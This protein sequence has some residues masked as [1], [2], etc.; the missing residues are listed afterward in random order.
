[1]TRSA[2]VFYFKFRRQFIFGIVLFAICLSYFAVALL[3]TPKPMEPVSPF[4]F[5]I[6]IGF[7]AYFS[8]PFLLAR[9]VV[10]DDSALTFKPIN[11]RYP[12]DRIKRIKQVYKTNDR[13]SAVQL[14]TE[15]GPNVWLPMAIIGGPEIVKMS[16]TN[17]DGQAFVRS[18]EKRIAINAKAPL[19]TIGAF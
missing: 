3:I 12:M 17:M 11:L 9:K 5:L 8:A 13:I 6:M 15:G 18:L 10:V 7:G 1:M 16:L 19:I 4:A 2:E 14:I